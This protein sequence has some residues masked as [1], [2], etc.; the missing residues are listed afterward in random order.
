M[1]DESERAELVQ[2]QTQRH[3]VMSNGKLC[4]T[5]ISSDEAD[6]EVKVSEREELRLL[7]KDLKVDLMYSKGANYET[8]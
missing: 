1:P 8:T 3:A 4:L 7:D 2:K 5:T 6:D